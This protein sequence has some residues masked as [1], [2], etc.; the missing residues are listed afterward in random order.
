MEPKGGGM[1]IEK[2]A[3]LK[4]NGGIA[5]KSRL[6]IKADLFI[7]RCFVIF[8]VLSLDRFSVTPPNSQ[9]RIAL[10]GIRF[11]MIKIT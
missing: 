1:F 2:I 8:V 6:V 7:E 11:L 3:M 5:K 4:G 10:K 9:A